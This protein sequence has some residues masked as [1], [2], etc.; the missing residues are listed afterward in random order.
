MVSP[1]GVLF[2][3]HALNRFFRSQQGARAGLTIDIVDLH[4]IAESEKG[5]TVTY[6]ERQ[7]LPGQ[8]VTQRF[9]TAVFDIDP[10]GRVM[11]RHLHET[12]YSV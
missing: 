3:S 2:D 9:A 10:D 1:I 7:T 4:I 6:T 11:W 8:N 5:A 12:F